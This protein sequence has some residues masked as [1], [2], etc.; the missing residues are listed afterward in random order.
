M[1]P[2]NRPTDLRWIALVTGTVTLATA[3]QLSAPQAAWH[4]RARR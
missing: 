4:R 3:L 1:L 2:T